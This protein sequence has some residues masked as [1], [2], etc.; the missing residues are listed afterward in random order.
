MYSRNYGFKYHHV[1][2]MRYSIKRRGENHMNR[3]IRWV[4]GFTMGI[5]LIG[6]STKEYSNAELQKDTTYV[7]IVTNHSTKQGITKIRFHNKEGEILKSETVETIGDVSYRKYD[8]ENYYLYGPGGLIKIDHELLTAEK[9][10]DDG[11]HDIDVET[12]EIYVSINSGGHSVITSLSG[13]Y[14]LCLD[15]RIYDMEYHKGLLYTMNFEGLKD[16]EQRINIIKGNEVIR[17]TKVAESGCFY[18]L[19]DD[20]YFLTQSYLLHL[21]HNT[22]LPFVDEMGNAISIHN[23]FNAILSNSNEDILVDS[24]ASGRSYYLME[25]VDDTIKLTEID[26]EG[27]GKV[28]GDMM[29][30]DKGIFIV[31]EEEELY[32]L[33]IDQ[34][35]SNLQKIDLD[36]KSNLL[37]VI[38]YEV[39]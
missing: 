27:V 13:S 15:Y 17:S 3:S 39:P 31:N 20:L 29:I 6:C 22:K 36:S 8:R 5:I 24:Q 11:I 2:T 30:K 19:N 18:V 35:S 38:G 33:T 16:G 34:G 10:A 4:V 7:S 26:T 14:E 9:L 23:T 25:K 37:L 21:E 1:N 32:K 12:D 28:K